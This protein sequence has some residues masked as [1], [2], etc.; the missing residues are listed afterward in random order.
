MPKRTCL[1]PLAFLAAYTTGHK[2][3]LFYA[4]GAALGTTTVTVPGCD[5][6]EA[7]SITLVKAQLGDPVPAGGAM[8][9]FKVCLTFTRMQAVPWRPPCMAHPAAASRPEGS[10]AAAR[11]RAPPRSRPAAMPLLHIWLVDSHNSCLQVE[12]INGA[13]A[14]LSDLSATAFYGRLAKPAQPELVWVTGASARAEL[15][16]AAP[17]PP[18]VGAPAGYSPQCHLKL[19]DKAGTAAVPGYEDVTISGTTGG[20]GQEPFVYVL[21]GVQ[22]GDYTARVYCIDATIGA[23]T[24]SDDSDLSA[25]EGFG[26]AGRRHSTARLPLPPDWCRG[27]LGTVAARLQPARSSCH[28]GCLAS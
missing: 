5:G 13:G 19:L 8:L 14:T 6:A 9:K 23:T 25:V 4:S 27:L 11:T 24:Q 10:R 17:S 16:F 18:P 3:H 26:E 15:R 22:P 12:S 28:A 21:N 7:C 1:P 20:E 2:L